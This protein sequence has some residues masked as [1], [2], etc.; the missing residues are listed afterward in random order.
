MFEINIRTL[1]RW[2]THYFKL[3]SSHL[4][5]QS[6]KTHISNV[7]FNIPK[8]HYLAYMEYAYGNKKAHKYTSKQSTRRKVIKN[9]KK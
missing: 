7:I 6:L 9:Y 4:S 5:F 2:I 3:E 8:K 1:Q